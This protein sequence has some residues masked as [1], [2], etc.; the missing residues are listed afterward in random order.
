METKEKD[1]AFIKA[2]SKITIQN[3]CKE[4]QVNKSNVWRGNASAEAIKKVREEIEK[5]IQQIKED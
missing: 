5:R 4:L 2:F 3:I 1:L